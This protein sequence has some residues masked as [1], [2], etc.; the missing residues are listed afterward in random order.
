MIQ[1]FI[2]RNH[3]SRLILVFA[4][5]GMDE[6]PFQAFRSQ[7]DDCCICFDYTD[8]SWDESLFEEYREIELFAWSFGVWAASHLLQR[9]QLP[10]V[11]KTAIN[12]TVT[13]INDRTGIPC[14]IFQATEAHLDEENYKR[15]LRRM[16][17]TKSRLEE[18]MNVAPHRSIES[19]K[20]ELSAI[21]KQVADNSTP[22]YI[23]DFAMIGKADR[24]FPA[25]NQ[26]NAWHDVPCL[27]ID[28]P[29]YI[30]FLSVMHLHAIDKDKVRQSF[31]K[32]AESYHRSALVQKNI[33]ERLIEIAGHH[34]VNRFS[35]HRVLEIGCG[36]GW[37][38]SL[39]VKRYPDAEYTLNDLCPSMTAYIQQAI[40]ETNYR[41]LAGD[42]ET[43]EFSGNYDLIASA[44]AIQWFSN[45]PGFLQH[46][47]QILS[48]DGYAV[49]ST[50][51]ENNLKEIK[52][53]TGNG[54]CY[55]SRDQL[56]S[57][58]AP[59]FEIDELKE[60]I[61]TMEFDSP[62]EVLRHLKQTGVN[63]IGNTVW[64]PSDLHRFCQEYETRFT[65]TNGKVRL[66]YHPI[67]IV[68][69]KKR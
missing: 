38:T 68:I 69:H 49:F 21:G 6:R 2:Q 63:G 31:S 43:L 59:Y 10:I 39:L 54:L 5:W 32:A 52:T 14:E 58:L 66:T 23:W 48:T 8:L 53:L 19:L 50:F 4:G 51:G 42:A 1:K 46:I 60:E 9:T 16:C 7:P 61:I 55:I 17:G 30:P 64:T 13:G 65:M 26:R 37:F 18:F 3:T 67:Y 36:T 47:R 25:E 28:E 12:G 11:R 56:R 33:A 24:I 62:A 22:Q 35:P 20:A 29:H 41:F 45:L 34:I 44:S 27:E 57:L 15:F 40:P